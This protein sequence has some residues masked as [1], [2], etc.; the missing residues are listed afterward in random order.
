M[1]KPFTILCLGA[2]LSATPASAQLSPSTG[3][4]SDLS[5]RGPVAYVYVASSPGN[6]GPNV[7]VGYSASSNGALTRIP[8]SPFHRNIRPMAV[9]GQ[10]LMGANATNNHP[11]IYTLQIGSDGALTYVTSTPCVQKDNQCLAAFNLF[12]DHTGSDL[13]VMELNDSDQ[14]NTASFAV[15]KSSGSLNYLGDAITGTLPNDSA[16]TSFIGDNEYAYLASEDGCMYYTIDGFQREASGLLNLINIQFN[17]PTPPPGVSIYYPDLAVTD[18]ANHVAILEQPTNAPECAS[19]PVQLAV[20]TA[21]ASGNL[22]TK[23]TYKNMP[24]SL[25]QNPNDMKMSPSG[26]LL[27]VGGLQG[28]QIFHFNGANPIT[29]YTGL[30]TSDPIAQM[31]WDNQNHLYAISQSSGKLY[32]FTITATEHQQAQ[33]S[34]HAISGPQYIAVQPLTH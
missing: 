19:G 30:L 12:F 5:S 10:Y 11:K 24:A 2:A 17:L 15:D 4:Q 34:P 3:S 25:I 32:V 18:H 33:G 22:H 23:S 6:E 9:N 20:Y 14:T 16:G 21:D 1:F 8:G 7:I 28:L 31:F 13:Y 26:R 29:H 27:A